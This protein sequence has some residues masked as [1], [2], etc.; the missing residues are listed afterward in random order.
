MPLTPN[1]PCAPRG[2]PRSGAT[3]STSALSSVASVSVVATSGRGTGLRLRLG[4]RVRLG[5][6]LRRRALDRRLRVGLRDAQ[7]GRVL[8]RL[9]HRSSPFSSCAGVAASWRCSASASASIGGGRSEVADLVAQLEHRVD[10]HLR[11]RRAAGQVHVDRHD[12]VDALDDRVVVEHAAGA[13]ADAHREHPLGVRHLVVDLAQHGGHLLAHPAGHDH[14]VGLPR[15]GPEDLLAP[16]ARVVA[17]GAVGHH[18]DRAAGQAERRRP[19]RRA[20]HVAEDVL[21]VVSRTPVGSCSSTPMALLLLIPARPNPSPGRRGAA[22]R[23]RRR[24]R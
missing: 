13:G 19:E 22:R 7:A 10:Q 6:A 24:R 21:D 17:R 9:A 20:P 12:V 2:S 1:M 18:L 5:L 16:A 11:P 15:R 4:A 3:A 23:S 14:Q 8:R